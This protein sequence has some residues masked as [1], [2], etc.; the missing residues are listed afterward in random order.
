MVTYSSV[1]IRTRGV[2]REVRV[3]TTPLAR[4]RSS[5]KRSTSNGAAL[6]PWVSPTQTQLDNAFE[7]DGPTIMGPDPT[8]QCDPICMIALRVALVM[9]V[10][11]FDSR[12]P[13]SRARRPVHHNRLGRTY[14]G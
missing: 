3:A 10:F 9:T 14:R 8:E 5:Q 11:V 12:K 13:A 2:E 4:G 1:F 6:P 7:V